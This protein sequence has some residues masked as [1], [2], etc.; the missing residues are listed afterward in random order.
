MNT[1]SNH[2][3]PVAENLLNQGFATTRPGRVWVTDIT[4]VSTQ[5]GLLYLVGFMELR[6]CEVV[7]YATGDRMT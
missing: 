6:T 7:G 3:L 2:S 1:N 4:Y 5:E